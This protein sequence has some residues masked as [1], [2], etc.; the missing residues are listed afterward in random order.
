MTKHCFI[1]ESG[2]MDHQGV[3]SVALIT[4]EGVNSAQ[5]LHDQIMTALDSGYLARMKLLKKERK[6]AHLP[7]LHYADMSPEQKRTVGTRLGQAKITVYSAH[8]FH[9]DE[10]TYEERFAIYTE[11][12]KIC[13]QKALFEHKELVV[14]IAK[15]G[16]WQKYDNDFCTVLRELPEEFCRTGDY[17][18][19]TFELLSAV[20]P[21]IQLADFYVGAVRDFVVNKSA[22]MPYSLVQEQILCRENYVLETVPSKK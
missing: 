16:G 13:V 3:M 15:Q 20:K 8:H 1:D 4:L 11:L 9:I 19:A 7:R 21:G 22:L 6:S 10:K 18:K 17:H 14:N 12:V 2:T 5:R